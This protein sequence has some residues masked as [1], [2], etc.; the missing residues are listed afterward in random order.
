MKDEQIERERGNYKGRE[1]RISEVLSS[2]HLPHKI[3]VRLHCYRPLNIE[4]ADRRNQ[5]QNDA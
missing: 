2:P 3:W 5:L 1:D 4:M